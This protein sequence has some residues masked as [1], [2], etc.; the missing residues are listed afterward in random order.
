MQA[1]LK[2]VISSNIESAGYCAET[3]TLVVKFKSGKKYKYPDV[4]PE[5]YKDFEATFGGAD[6]KSAGKFFYANIRALACEEVEE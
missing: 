5:V 1:E 6:G 3:N 2:P 4:S